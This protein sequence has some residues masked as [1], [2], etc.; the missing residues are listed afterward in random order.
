M[1]LAAATAFGNIMTDD[2]VQAVPQHCPSDI[3][4][5]LHTCKTTLSTHA[6]KA[7]RSKMRGRQMEIKTILEATSSS[8]FCFL[9][10]IYSIL[11]SGS[12]PNTNH[13][14]T[15]YFLRFSLQRT[16]NFDP[17]SIPERKP[18]LATQ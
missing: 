15:L 7:G 13:F 17:R 4:K 18:Y 14:P 9:S 11:P 16:I 8:P 2:V 5:T 10:F 1:Q 12:K 6:Q 3:L